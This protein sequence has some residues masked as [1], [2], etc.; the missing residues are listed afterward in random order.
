[1]SKKSHKTVGN[2]F[3]LTIFDLLKKEPELDPDPYLV[4]IMDLDLVPGD[5]ETYKSE[6]GPG[7]A[8]LILAIWNN[9]HR[10]FHS[11]V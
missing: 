2:K 1:M 10:G 5:P 3:F 9:S 6:S 7:S 8:I 11:L 4:L